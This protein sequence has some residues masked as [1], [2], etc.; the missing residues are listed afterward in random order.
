MRHGRLRPSFEARPRGRAPQDDGGGYGGTVMSARVLARHARD[1][2]H[3]LIPGRAPPN[4]GLPEF[5]IVI[6]PGRQQPTW[7]R[8]RGIHRTP[9]RGYGFR[10]RASRAPD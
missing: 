7:M 5:G 3:A 10:A 1:A 9:S 2:T 8:G 6:R 4:S